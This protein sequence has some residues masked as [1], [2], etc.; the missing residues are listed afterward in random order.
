MG[1]PSSTAHGSRQLS[2]IA[3]S[4]R[5]TKTMASANVGPAGGATFSW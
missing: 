1:E 2:Y 3:A 5:N 4:R